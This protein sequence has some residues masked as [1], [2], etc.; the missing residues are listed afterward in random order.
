MGLFVR[1]D[2]GYHEDIRQTGFNRY[3]QLLSLRFAQW[4]KVGM[5][6]LAGL[7]PLS[8]GIACAILT[9]SVLV[10]IPCSILGGTIAGP[11]LAGLYDSILRGLRDDPLP[12]KDA[13]VRSW[14]QDRRESLLPG[15]VMGLMTGLYAFMAML[16][17]WAQVP[18]SLGTV[19]LYLFSL[20]LVLAANTLLWPQLVLFRQ[21]PSTRLR[22]AALFLVKRSWRVM[23]AGLVQL[24][25]LAILVLF[26]PWT[27]LLLPITGV[28]Y[29]VFLSQLLIY[30]ALDEDLHIE[31]SFEERS[32][33]DRS[34]HFSDR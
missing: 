21:D 3:K 8:A 23:G 19:A 28:W 5:I 25:Y 32:P 24:A 1:E 6:T 12:W 13:W 2:P 15:A 14:K 26:A 9:S 29:V 22:N 18:P 11:F 7:A 17:W 34:E 20:L 27:V 30:G 33:A 31:G 4:W 10:L 16:F